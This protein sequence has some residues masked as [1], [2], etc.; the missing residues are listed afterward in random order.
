[1]IAY[2]EVFVRHVRSG[3]LLQDPGSQCRHTKI[4]VLFEAT[5][6]VQ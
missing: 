2:L 5:F 3:I 6:E 4:D 1:M